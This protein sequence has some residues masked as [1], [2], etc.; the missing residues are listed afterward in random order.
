MDSDS[1]LILFDGEEC[2]THHIAIQKEWTRKGGLPHETRAWVQEGARGVWGMCLVS[3]AREQK[4]AA[5][6]TPGGRMGYGW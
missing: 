3:Q 6:R 1:P 5:R 4:G 2:R